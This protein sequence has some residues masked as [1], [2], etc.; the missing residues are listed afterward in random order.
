MAQGELGQAYKDGE[1]IVTQ[2]SR[3]REM[4]VI[5]S[6]SAQVEIET[7]SAGRSVIA[8]I[9][10]G[11]FFGEM[12]VFQDRPRSATVRA[13]GPTRVL[14]IDPQS[15]LR[16]IAQQPTLALRMLERMAQ[17]VRDLNEAAARCTCGAGWRGAVD[18]G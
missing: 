4:Y 14:A 10:E 3:G 13:L 16:R 18:E 5:L 15:L 9:A 7:D 17:R 8:T 11:D 1:I 2:G 6:G 12:A